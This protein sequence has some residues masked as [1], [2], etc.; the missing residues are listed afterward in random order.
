MFLKKPLRRR[1]AEE[2]RGTRNKASEFFL[3]PLALQQARVLRE[4]LR[5]FTRALLSLFIVAACK[6]VELKPEEIMPED[7][8]SYRKMAIGE[9]QYAIEF[10]DSDRQAFKFDEIGCMVNFEGNKN[11]TKP[12]AYFVMDFDERKWIKAEMPSTFVLPS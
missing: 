4:G 12:A 9:K 8:C 3:R 10:I 7:M 2:I 6:P 5:H 11:T 1:D